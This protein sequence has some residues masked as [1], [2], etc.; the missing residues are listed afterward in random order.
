MTLHIL[1]LFS[2]PLP[3]PPE[4]VN[5]TPIFQICL[6]AELVAVGVRE[7]REKL[8]HLHNLEAERVVYSL[9]AGGNFTKVALQ[10]LLSQLFI[11]FRP[12]W[13]PV[14]KL[15]ESHAFNMEASNFWSVYLPFMERVRL[16]QVEKIRDPSAG[17]EYLNLR[18]SAERIDFG[19][20]RC[21]TLGCLA[22]LGSVTE[23]AHGVIVPA[24]LDFWNNEY[25]INDGTVAQTEDLTGDNQTESSKGE[26]G[27]VIKLL[28]SHL[29]VLAAFKH[30]QKMTREPEVT[31]ILL[32]LLSHRSGDIQKLAL[33]CLMSYGYPYLTPYK[34]NLY[35]MLDDK[36]F[37]SEITAFSVDP[38]NS[39]IKADH[40]AGL[41]SILCRILYGKMMFKTGT[42]SSGK[43]NIQ[44]RQAVVLRYIAGLNDSEI[45]G[46]IDLAFQLF[47]NLSQTENV[48][49]FV[50]RTMKEVDPKSALP[51][52]RIQGALVLMGTVFAKLG[53]LMG[54]TLPK[55]LH[56]LLN[57]SAH[58]SGLLNQRNELEARHLNQLKTLRGICWERLTQ[59]FKK[60]ERYPWTAVEIEAVFHVYV[61]PQLEMLSDQAYSGP[62]PMLRLFKVW[63]ENSRY[64]CLLTTWFLICLGL[65][66][67]FLNRYFVL[68]GKAHPD[69]PELT[70]L[71]PM[72]ELLSSS[73]AT[74][75]VCSFLMEIVDELVKTPDYGGI[76]DEDDPEE[77]IHIKPDFSV[78][79]DWSQR[80][81]EDDSDDHG[82]KLNYGSA[83][84]I[85]Y[86][87]SILTYLQRFLS[88][89]L[90]AR[91][92]NVLMRV[93]QFVKEAQLSTELARMIIPAIKLSISRN[94]KNSTLEEKVTQYLSTLENLVQNAINPQQFIG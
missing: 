28:S 66:V 12:L 20:T 18:V 34:E 86:M 31:R 13:E 81:I 78:E 24:F 57:I 69:R 5:P 61:W 76:V 63:S 7:Q 51:L 4:N 14:Q 84:L 91:D 38:T 71:K 58:V 43:D 40:R 25:C 53:N 26:R 88:H 11:N 89:G 50:S 82:S 48:L 67:S 72:L 75:S 32:R 74:S 6:N 33:D 85:P 27:N 23:K 3:T 70:I 9:P 90:N 36:S 68:F 39:E 21:L 41:T 22:R 29:S 79:W 15:I 94:R 35:R 59:F 37:R 83:L 16:C 47:S 77:P 54:S 62:T 10:Y 93:S 30:P 2:P 52:K 8:V 42:G 60:F 17:M 46:F 55:L 92:L 73:K 49:E 1:S 65:D 56:I 45:D 19:N 64:A 80:M 87:S 44:H